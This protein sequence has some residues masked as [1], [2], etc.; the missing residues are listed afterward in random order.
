MALLALSLGAAC[1][2]APESAISDHASQSEVPA[3]PAPKSAAAVPEQA[4]RPA[5]ASP[6]S[7]AAEPQPKAAPSQPSAA[8]AQPQMQAV[9]PTA[10]SSPASSSS[11]A[12]KSEPAAAEP[13]PTQA[14]NEPI[15]EVCYS[16]ASS[17]HPAT[18]AFWETFNAS[19]YAR[20]DDLIAQLEAAAKEHPDEEEFAFLLAHANLWRAAEAQ[21]ANDLLLALD[22]TQAA[23]KGFERA[24]A[25]CPTDARI[26]AWLGPTK[27]LLGRLLGETA[28]REKGEEILAKGA[29]LYPAFVS[30]SNFI[31]YGDEPLDSPNFKKV[32]ESARY[33]VGINDGDDSY[34]QRTGDSVCSNSERIPHN[35]QG[36]ALYVGDVFVK[37]RDRDAA[38]AAYKLVDL[39]APDAQSWPF[40]ALLEGRISN[41]DANI[42]AASSASELDDLEYAWKLGTGA[43]CSTCHRR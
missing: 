20:R 36:L 6:Q 10:A 16:E 38:L 40:R 24:A 7:A 13:S 15:L 17:N 42:V 12:A 3:A 23:E 2:N 31:A 9:R 1:A 43:T 30:F 35:L 5:A 4:Q 8:S 39:A 11:A 33:F 25:L 28:L 19:D 18:L 32:I 21:G 14:D 37:A 27:I 29:E 34:C 22:S 41:L 26:A